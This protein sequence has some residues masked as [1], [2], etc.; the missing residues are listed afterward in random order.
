MA[1]DR[2][3]AY[4]NL[5][6]GGFETKPIP[7]AMSDVPLPSRLMVTLICLSS[8]SRWPAACRSDITGSVKNH[9]VTV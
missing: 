6:P 7:V 5:S 9:G 2:K 4:I 3:I 8:V 1:L